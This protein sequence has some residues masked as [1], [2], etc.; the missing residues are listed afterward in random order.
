MS[1]TQQLQTT[2]SRKPFSIGARVVRSSDPRGTVGTVERVSLYGIEGQPTWA[3]AVRTDSDGEVWSG[4][5]ETPTEGAWRLAPAGSWCTF[6][7]CIHHLKPLQLV[8]PVELAPVKASRKRRVAQAPVNSSDPTAVAIAALTPAGKE[9]MLAVG[10]KRFDF[11]DEGIAAGSGNWGEG[12]SWQ[13]AAMTDR[14]PRSVPG[15]MS[16]L[17]VSGLWTI[18][19]GDPDQGNWWSLTELGAAVAL[20]LTEANK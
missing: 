11:F 3:V 19:A 20:K 1:A 10:M 17:S 15:I 18:S 7:E 8:A 14:K 4:T 13:F 16:R 12:M 9:F 6:A 5:Q 2:S